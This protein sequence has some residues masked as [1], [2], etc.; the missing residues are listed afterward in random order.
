M[1]SHFLKQLVSSSNKIDF[2]N[3][4]PVRKGGTLSLVFVVVLLLRRVRLNLM[5]TLC[6]RLVVYYMVAAICAFVCA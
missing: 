6:S 2:R 4:T 3:L 5:P 1:L